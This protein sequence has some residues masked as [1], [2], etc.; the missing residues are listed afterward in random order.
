MYFLTE[1]LN[2]RNNIRNVYCT[3]K[4]YSDVTLNTKTI[5]LHTKILPNRGRLHIVDS[6]I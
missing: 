5:N 6:A 1:F 3:D 2:I 4:K